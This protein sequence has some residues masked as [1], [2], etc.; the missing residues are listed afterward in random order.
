MAISGKFQLLEEA[1]RRGILPPEKK[2]LYDEAVS[3]GLVGNKNAKT[4]EQPQQTSALE[5]VARPALKAVKGIAVGTIGGLGD[6]AQEAVNLPGYLGNK[7][8]QGSQFLY[9]KATGQSDETPESIITGQKKKLEPFKPILGGVNTVSPMLRK[10]FDDATGGLTKPR[11]KTEE[12][13]EI[14]EEI[15][16]GFVGPGVI[17]KGAE[18]AGKAISKLNPK[19]LLQK[20]AGITAK[21]PKTLKAFEE[22][23]ISPRLADITE[24][25][26]TKTF[27]NLLGNFPGSRGVI[28]KSTQNQ[29]DD[30]T[31]QLAGITAEGGTIQQ[32]GKTIQEGAKNVGQALLNRTEKLYKDLDK[33]IPKTSTGESAL[34]PTNNLRA[35]AERPEIQDVVAVGEG[36]TGKILN[37]LKSII[38]KEGNISYDR[39]KIFRSTIG[40][41]LQSPTLGGDERGA[42]KQIYGA[43]SQDMKD[44][45]VA[46]GGDKALQT[47]NKANNAFGRYTNLLESKIN[48]LI[49]A[50]TPETVYSMAMSGSKQGGSN[51]RGIM[52]TLDPEQKEFVQGTITKRMGL[53]NSGEQDAA[54]EVFSP[55]K[56]LTEWNKLSPEAKANIYEKPKIEA[57]DNLNKVISQIKNTSKAKQSSNNLPY[58]SWAGLGGLT[59]ANP[60]AGLGAVGGAHISANMMTNPRFINWLARAPKAKTP[61]D[62]SK[63]INQLSKIAAS[64]PAIRE[65]TLD[66]LKSITIDE[67]Q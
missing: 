51:I 53:A 52:K 44:A 47:F 27:Q 40:R 11:N 54:G 41:K 19:S 33:F 50:K 2:A 42:I 60:A 38:N 58:L 46:N 13:L 18:A 14:A 61:A 64:N 30:I 35:I 49:E 62:I 57:I 4:H 5:E 39:L 3:R 24:G 15:A 20:A 28:E 36:H 7:I 17:S 34:V 21:S 16:G 25:Q 45:V 43:L 37:H 6:L 32:A 22:A 8:A 31:K 29:V 55:N 66:Y 56:F 67:N 12:G 23:G 1:N 26:T 63:H 9:N 10:A 65:D 48:P 59:V